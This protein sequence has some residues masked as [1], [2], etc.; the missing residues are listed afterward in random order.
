VDKSATLVSKANL[1]NKAADV[2]V[3]VVR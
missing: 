2:P 1:S 3:P